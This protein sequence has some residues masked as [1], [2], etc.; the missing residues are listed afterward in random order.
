ML[1]IFVRNMEIV[2]IARQ[3]ETQLD[4]LQH[5]RQPYRQGTGME[6]TEDSLQECGTPN[7]PVMINNNGDNDNARKPFSVLFVCSWCWFAAVDV[8]HWR[9]LSY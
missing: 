8:V 3:R 6:M 2:G 7:S 4:C 1:V 5:Q 9:W